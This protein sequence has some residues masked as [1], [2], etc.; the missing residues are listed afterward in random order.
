MKENKKEVFAWVLYDFANTSFSVIMVT[1]V[2]AVYFRDY[3]VGEISL[4]IPG[5]PNN[6]GDFLWSIAGSLSMF[7]VALTSPILGAAADYSNRK[8]WFVFF[9]SFLCISSTILLYFPGE[10]MIF[11]AMALFVLANFGFEGSLVFYNAFLPKIAR[12]ENIGRISGSGFAFGYV[13]AIISLLI[14]LFYANLA[15]DTGDITAMAP[16]F[17]WAALFFFIFSLPFYFWVD[18]PPMIVERKHQNYIRIGILRTVET[19]KKLRR[20][21]QLLRFLGAYFVYIDGVNTVMFFGAL[22][23]TQTLGFT[24]VEV[25]IFFAI[26]QFAA[27]IGAFGLGSLSDRIG[28][29]PTIN[30]TLVMWVVVTVGA[31]FSYDAF[32]FYIVG[33]IA[34]AAMGA[35]QAASRVLMAHFI[36][37][38]MEA[39]FYGFYALMGKFSAILGP[40]VFGL[41]SSVTGSQRLAVLSISLFFISGYILLQRV[42][43]RVNYK[44]AHII[45]S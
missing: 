2:F 6:P 43:T 9:Y 23:A 42:D 24:M 36:P 20:F 1:V 25:I 4:N 39:E 21:P 33:L 3:I 19:I 7:L 34:G 38:G 45:N 37:R 35:S 15:S 22:F 16:S 44:D 31:Y 10:G 32:S 41:I 8:K 40:L 28:A 12:P 13:G 27:I 11:T 17:V 30:I 26:T 5:L 14:A 18:E 29:K